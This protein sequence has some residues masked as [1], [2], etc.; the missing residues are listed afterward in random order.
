MSYFKFYNKESALNKLHTLPSNNGIKLFS[1]DINTTGAKNFFLCPYKQL[2][3]YIITSQECCNFY[4]NYNDNEP[5]K[6]FFDIDC[7][8][9]ELNEDT[10]QEIF[11]NHILNFIKEIINI[12]KIKYDEQKIIILTA[13]TNIKYSFHIIFPNIIMNNVIQIKSLLTDTNNNLINDKIVDLNVY[14]TGCFR[15][16]LSSKK[17]KNNKLKIYQCIGYESYTNKQ[18][19]MDSLLLNIDNNI[20]PITYNPKNII[21]ILKNKKVKSI[22]TSSKQNIIKQIIIENTNNDDL[23]KNISDTYE[24]VDLQLLEQIIDIIGTKYFESYNDW[25][26]IGCALK[27]ANPESFN[28]WNK[29]SAKLNN[30]DSQEQCKKKWD[31]FNLNNNKNNYS[32]DTLKWIAKKQNIIE[33]YKLF[34]CE[35]PNEYQNIKKS[36]YELIIDKEFLFNDV[37]T[38][39]KNKTCDV[40]VLIDNFMTDTNFIPNNKKIIKNI[41]IKSPYGT[42]KTKLIKQIITEY[43][44]KRVLFVSYRKT[45]SSDIHGCFKELNFNIY[46]NNNFKSD[47]FICQIDSLH[48]LIDFD[49]PS[50]D[51]VILDEIESILNH[52]NAETLRDKEYKFDLLKGIINNSKKCIML[53]GDISNRSLAFVSNNGEYYL[54]QNNKVKT[55]KH[56]IF[57]ENKEP[58]DKLLNDDINNSKKIVIVSM[59]SEIAHSYYESLKTKYSVCIHT[60]KTDDS[61]FND[62]NDVNTFWSQFDIVIYSP[63]IESGVDFNVEHFDKM[64]CILCSKSTS[65]RGFLQMINRIRKLKS[66]DINIYLNKIPFCENVYPYTYYE[67]KKYFYTTV[68]KYAEKK[69]M[70]DINTGKATIKIPENLYNEIIIFNLLETYNK[71]TMYFIKGLLQLLKNKSYTYQFIENI[72]KKVDKSKSETNNE[73][74][75]EP[76]K[77]VKCKKNDENDNNISVLKSSIINAEDISQNAFDKLLIKQN[78]SKL[79]SDEKMKMEKFYYKK[80]FCVDNIDEQFIKK[81]YRKF[82]VISGLK[83]LFNDNNNDYNNIDFFDDEYK[84]KFN[85]MQKIERKNTILYLLNCLNFSLDDIKNNSICTNKNKLPKQIERSEFLKIINE[86]ILGENKFFTKYNCE[87]FGLSKKSFKTEKKDGKEIITEESIK[88][89]LGSINTVI[90]NYGVELKVNQKKIRNKETQELKNANYYYIHINKDFYNYL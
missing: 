60:S 11:I 65:Q 69:I 83:Y 29:Y 10:T 50:Y 62:L 35:I 25:I 48:K 18:I 31:T 85:L 66:N 44:L 43:D 39:I 24:N 78:L 70:Y 34:P 6:L 75:N 72:N 80:I 37:N 41:I 2:Y 51:L 36:L 73:Q 40:S 55:P 76:I 58:F 61:L 17:G 23:D 33:Y 89:F 13:S 57:Y 45:L 71:N 32:I 16:F 27:N 67:I 54:I 47:R 9:N 19:F 20:K 26:M 15:T 14:R 1:F 3:N 38:V 46:T 12:L 86:L 82:H 53:D 74:N 7:K 4:E 77:K 28:I 88:S 63:T 90:N 59:S 21:P 22:S 49:I 8:I 42:G 87:L 64:Y 5:I 68:N 30:Y 84:A 56:F 81:Y 52:F 79:T